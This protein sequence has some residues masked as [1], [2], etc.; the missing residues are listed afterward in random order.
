MRLHTIIFRS[1][2]NI[3]QGAVGML[4]SIPGL[5]SP[6]SQVLSSK[7][8]EK[9]PRKKIVLKSSF[10]RAIFWLPIEL[11]KKLF[12]KN[13]LTGYL[14]LFLIALFSLIVMF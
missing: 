10:Y 2:I 8:V 4:A 13:I 5:I 7:L 6:I 11:L 1:A 12:Y 9:Y 14:P 3:T